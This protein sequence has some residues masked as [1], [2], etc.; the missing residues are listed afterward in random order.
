MSNIWT[1]HLELG[2][3]IRVRQQQSV[4]DYF[5]KVLDDLQK[6]VE[7]VGLTGVDVDGPMSFHMFVAPE[8]VEQAKTNGFLV[9]EDSGRFC[10]VVWEWVIRIELDP[11][12]C[13]VNSLWA[14]IAEQCGEVFTTIRVVDELF[15]DNE[16][17]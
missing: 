1:R 17:V 8:K 3:R 9:V 13:Q 6:V 7:E 11:A 16:P 10:L 14:K 2:Y 15:T 12:Q 5:S 4:E